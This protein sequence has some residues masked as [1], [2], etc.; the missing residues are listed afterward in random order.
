[1]AG[2]ESGKYRRKN[3]PPAHCEIYVINQSNSNL[4]SC[5]FTSIVLRV[6]GELYYQIK[7][8]KL[9]FN[10]LKYRVCCELGF[11]C[12]WAD[13]AACSEYQLQAARKLKRTKFHFCDRKPPSFFYYFTT[14]KSQ[15]VVVT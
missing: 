4:A 12:R 3:L 7:K 6:F 14:G 15:L 2:G 5:L 8:D 11:P 13:S 10:N 1:V 9:E